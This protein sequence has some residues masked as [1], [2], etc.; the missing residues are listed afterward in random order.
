M[1]NEPPETPENAPER[2][3]NGAEWAVVREEEIGAGQVRL[4]FLLPPGV[5]HPVTIDRASDSDEM[6]GRIADSLLA[7]R[8]KVKTPRGPQPR[9]PGGLSPWLE[10]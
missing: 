9:P 7:E 6:R 10:P 2:L 4:T 3:S 1:A 8:W 5:R